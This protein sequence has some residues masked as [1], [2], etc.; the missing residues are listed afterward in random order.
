MNTIQSLLTGVFRASVGLTTAAVVAQT[1]FYVGM[2]HFFASDKAFKNAIILVGTYVNKFLVDGGH[3]AVVFD[4]LE[5]VKQGSQPEGIHFV[6]PILQ[7]F[8]MI[9]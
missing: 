3:R 6:V 2:F 4:R 7:V 5:G 1:C 9:Y 8:T